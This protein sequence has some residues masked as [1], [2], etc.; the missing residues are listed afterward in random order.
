ACRL[1]WT[2]ANPVGLPMYT[3][4]GTKK[5]PGPRG[6]GIP[7]D[8]KRSPELTD[9][10]VNEAGSRTAKLQERKRKVGGF[11]GSALNRGLLMSIFMRRLLSTSRQQRGSHA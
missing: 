6:A 1:L 7:R 9:R 4:L 11:H 2:Q 3:G 8:E 5:F 10:P